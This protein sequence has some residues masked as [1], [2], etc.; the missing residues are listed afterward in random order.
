MRVVQAQRVAVAVTASPCRLK[1]E[2]QRGSTRPIKNF[3]VTTHHCRLTRFLSSL[4]DFHADCW[5]I[6]GLESQA[7]ISSLEDTVRFLSFWFSESI[8]DAANGFYQFGGVAHFLA[9]T[10]NVNVDRSLEHHGV[11]T[12]RCID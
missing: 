9:K 2:H 11:L 5:A 6:L 7:T 8:A 1:P 3:R 4:R 12:Q 10:A